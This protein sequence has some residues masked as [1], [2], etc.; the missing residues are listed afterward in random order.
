M[1]PIAWI[2]RVAGEKAKDIAL[3]RDA[4]AKDDATDLGEVTDDLIYFPRSRRRKHRGRATIE[5]SP[6]LVRFQRPS[7]RSSSRS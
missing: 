1:P 2:V 6:K 7:L 3:R 4:E 5:D